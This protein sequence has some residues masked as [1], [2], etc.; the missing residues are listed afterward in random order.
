MSYINQAV[1]P[2]SPIGRFNPCKIRLDQFKKEACSHENKG[3][4]SHVVA[5]R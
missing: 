4:N 1:T 3:F 5:R 2:I